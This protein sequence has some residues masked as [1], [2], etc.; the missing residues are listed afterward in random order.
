LD[1]A[2]IAIRHETPTIAASK[3][4]GGPGI[5]LAKQ[6]EEG[7]KRG[8][9]LIRRMHDEKQDWLGQNAEAIRENDE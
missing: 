4:L 2:R 6:L 7:H 9:E 8:D 5:D 1:A 3:P